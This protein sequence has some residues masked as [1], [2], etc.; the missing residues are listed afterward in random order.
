VVRIP[1]RGVG[2]KAGGPVRK[3]IQWYRWEMLVPWATVV[4]MV[5]TGYILWQGQ[6]GFTVWQETGRRQ[7]IW[8]KQLKEWSSY[9]LRCG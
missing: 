2:A 8:P 6:T 7:V 3:S 5:R 4:E 9:H 1:G